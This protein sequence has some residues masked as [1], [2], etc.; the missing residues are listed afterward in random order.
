MIIYGRDDH[1]REAPDGHLCTK[2]EEKCPQGVTPL[3][4]I[5]VLVAIYGRRM[6]RHSQGVFGAPISVG[7]KTGLA[8]ASTSTPA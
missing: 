2:P 8:T 4:A 5:Y 1:L 7:A 6:P 3:M